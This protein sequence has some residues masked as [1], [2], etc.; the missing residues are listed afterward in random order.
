MSEVRSIAI[1]DLVAR[2]D[3][4]RQ[5]FDEAGLRQLA[6]SIQAQGFIGQITVRPAG[7]GKWEVL[8]G[9]RRRRAAILAGLSELPAVIVELDDRA[10]REF[11]LLDNLNRED[12]LPWEEGAGFAELVGLGI[13]AE[14][15]AG[16][17]GRSV[18]YVRGRI[19]LVKSAG[20]KLREEYLAG[21]VTLA[22][23]LELSKLPCRVLA[24]VRCPKCKV[25]NAEGAQ[26][27]VACRED[28]SGEVR[29]PAG[30]PQEAAA[31]L[32]RGKSVAAV[33][34]LVEQVKQTYGLS[35]KP[36]QTSLGLDDRQISEG[37]VRVRS[38][39]ERR[40]AE[41][42]SVAAWRLEQVERAAG[43][44]TGDQQAAVLAAFATA[45]GT[46]R[47][48]EVRFRRAAGVQEDS[49]GLRLVAGAR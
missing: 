41:I 38:A 37:A 2:E 40:L 8:A 15:V 10:A 16:K 39:L 27:C 28:L 11:V 44:L 48:V 42:G 30:N 26:A 49:G 35:A 6:D 19:D 23:L 12:F 24:P 1:A 13:S 5:H 47:Q 36:V 9:H 34:D 20:V 46:L 29:F 33:Q 17:A 43:E 18:G 32:A 3:Q 22:A 45:I 14:A 7:A 31:R 25:V 4:P 21:G